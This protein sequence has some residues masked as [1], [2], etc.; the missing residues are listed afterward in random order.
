MVNLVASDCVGGRYFEKLNSEYKNP[1]IWNSFKLSDFIHLVKFWDSINFD[2]IESYI[3][4]GEY[5]KFKDVPTLILDGSMRLYFHHHHQM[6]DKKTPVK[7]HLDI[8]N[9]D[10]GYC[11]ILG[12]LEEKWHKRL[13][14]M[15]G[16]PVFCYNDKPAAKNAD[17]M[18]YINLDTNY[19]RILITCDSKYKQH[20]DKKLK[21]YIKPIQIMN[22]TVL[23]N[24]LYNK[25]Y[26]D[27]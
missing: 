3:S 8:D 9:I 17:I 21:V 12:Y 2:N 13:Q 5:G 10:L 16:E 24:D 18:E 20:E 26:F 19:N 27:F 11:D 15:K 14:R 4:T 7:L 6:D 25:G 22:S 23:C 1:F